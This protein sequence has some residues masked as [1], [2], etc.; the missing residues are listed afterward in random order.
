M[1]KD[2]LLDKE[3]INLEGHFESEFS[4]YGRQLLNV[5]LTDANKT[6]LKAFKDTSHDWLNFE[7]GYKF[8]VQHSPIILPDK[9][10]RKYV[11][12]LA[13]AA[14]HRVTD[15]VTIL[16]KAQVDV[17]CIPEDFNEDNIQLNLFL[18]LLREMTASYS[19]IKL[20]NILTAQKNGSNEQQRPGSN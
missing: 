12:S 5:G 3:N 15:K 11:C 20:R 9:N 17:N 16:Y 7:L 14:V 8:D 10:K 19:L 18:D 2:N 13:L 6:V 1:N 4:T